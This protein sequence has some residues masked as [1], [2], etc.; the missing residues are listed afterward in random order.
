MH[1]REWREMLD[2]WRVMD[3]WMGEMWD[4]SRAMNGWVKCGMDQES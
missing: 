3:G 4:G 2:G 1:A